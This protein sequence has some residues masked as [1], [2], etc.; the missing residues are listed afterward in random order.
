MK[1]SGRRKKVVMIPVH[2]KTANKT[3]DYKGFSL[4]HT[5]RH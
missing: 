2:K 3:D 1:D 5:L 4:C